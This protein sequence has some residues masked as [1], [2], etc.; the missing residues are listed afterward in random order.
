MSPTTGR[1]VVAVVGIGAMAE[2]YL[3]NHWLFYVVGALGAI[4]LWQAAFNS[5][6]FGDGY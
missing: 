3:L 1:V 2:A 4:G 6:I 5:K